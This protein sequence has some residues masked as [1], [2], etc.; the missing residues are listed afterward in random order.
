MFWQSHTVHTLKTLYNS[1]KFEPWAE[2]VK[3]NATQDLSDNCHDLLERLAGLIS[4]EFYENNKLNENDRE[5]I[6]RVLEMAAV[7]GKTL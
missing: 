1:E 2:A 3:Q 4:S 5:K 6:K 7:G